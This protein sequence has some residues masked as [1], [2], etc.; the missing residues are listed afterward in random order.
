MTNFVKT[1][2]LVSALLLVLCGFTFLAIH[3]LIISDMEI[4]KFINQVRR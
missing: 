2:L 1:F 4:E 3:Q